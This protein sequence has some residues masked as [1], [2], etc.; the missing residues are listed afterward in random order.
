MNNWYFFYNTKGIDKEGLKNLSLKLENTGYKYH[1]PTGLGA[2]PSPEQII[3]WINNNQFLSVVSINILSN[4]LYD[5]LKSIYSWFRSHKFNSKKV[6]VMEVFLH[7]R[8]VKS[9]R[10]RASLKFRIDQSP[11]K[12][13]IAGSLKLQLK[14]LHSSSEEQ[15]VCHICKKN[16]PEHCGFYLKR[17][18]LDKPICQDC[19]NMQMKN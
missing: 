12:K 6:P 10:T 19:Y 8:D 17:G 2:G 4:Y 11:N 3:L 18:K 16:I 5:L 9:T 13:I 7:F 14:F 15:S 1:Q